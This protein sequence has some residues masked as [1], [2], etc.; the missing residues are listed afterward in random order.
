MS[1]LFRLRLTVFF[2]LLP[3]ATLAF[4]APQELPTYWQKRL[5]IQLAPVEVAGSG[6]KVFSAEDTVHF[7]DQSLGEIINWMEEMN[8]WR[9]GKDRPPSNGGG[10]TPTPPNLSQVMEEL[11]RLEARINTLEQKLE[12]SRHTVQAPFKVIDAAGKTLMTVNSDKGIS[13]LR[14]GEPGKAMAELLI[15]GESARVVAANKSNIG[16]LN[17]DANISQAVLT[18]NGVRTALGSPEEGVNGMV[19]SNADSRQPLGEMALRPGKKFALR[20]YDEAG[21]VVVSAGTN[22]TTSGSGTV[23]AANTQGENVAFV[24]TSS[25]GQTGVVSVAKGGKDTAAL[26][27]E[28]R[29]IVLYNDAGEAITTL[30]KSQEGTGE[31]GNITIRQPD[32]EGIFSAGYN[33]EAGGGDA[34]VYRAKKQN[35]F[36]LG[37]GVPGMGAIGR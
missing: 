6:I 27:S 36:C 7:I 33:A 14:L 18:S 17:A 28:P 5:D 37:I 20:L 21:K 9:E 35:M 10:S 13:S 31:G 34:C 25:D 30:A 11:A 19:V 15:D 26:I 3:W 8:T 32:G 4:A 22:P 29:M 12:A 2:I 16:Y 23:M 1:I 24:G